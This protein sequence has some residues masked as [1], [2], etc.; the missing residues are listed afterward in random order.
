MVEPYL[1]ESY[2]LSGGQR[3]ILV[4]T[5]GFDDSGSGKTDTD[6]LRDIAVFLNST[7]QND[8]RLTGII[9][10]HR[11]SDNRVGGS[12]LRQMS[13]FRKLCGQ[14]SMANIVIAT[15]MW[16]HASRAD[17]VAREQELMEG[18]GFFKQMIRNGTKFMRQ[19][20]GEDSAAKIIDYFI[21]LK[22]KIVLDIQSEMVDK[23]K[24]LDETAAGQVVE[25]EL[26]K[27]REKH[28]KELEELKHEMHDAISQKDTQLAAELQ[29]VKQDIEGRLWNEQE[30]SRRLREDHNQMVQRISSQHQEE[31]RRLQEMLQYEQRNQNSIT[32]QL[33]SELNE[34]RNSRARLEQQVANLQRPTVVYHPPIFYRH[35]PWC[36][37]YNCY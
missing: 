22:S 2:A 5:P 6:I 4:D 10:L 11:I 1:C 31:S 29:R 13:M 9:Y 12:G 30:A 35:P 18:D 28:E 25:A 26:V 14:R 21:K 15:T 8:V 32:Q 34:E 27:L 24:R 16:G 37:C 7:Y 19:D 3:L 36:N 23:N 20:C 33:T 17:A